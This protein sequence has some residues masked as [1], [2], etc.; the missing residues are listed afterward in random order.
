MSTK[1]SK[2]S[3]YCILAN[4]KFGLYV[5]LVDSFDAKTREA[6]VREVRHVIHYKSKRGGLTSLA[7]F[8]LTNVGDSNIGAAAPSA[9][10]TGIVNVIE[11]SAE[12][13]ATFES[14]KQG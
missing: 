13:R 4:E 5:G 2:Q 8:G 12:A 3:P 1:K 9:T 7:V 14:A 11:C 6:K 10:L